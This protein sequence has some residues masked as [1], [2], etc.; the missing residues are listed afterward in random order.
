MG[1]YGIGVE[2]SMASIIEC[3]R[4][5]AASPKEPSK[6]TTRATGETVKVPLDQAVDHMNELLKTTVRGVRSGGVSPGRWSG[7]EVVAVG[8]DGGLD[9]VAE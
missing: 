4:A 8:V 2:R 3:H 9:A 5:N 1:S 7:D 6:I